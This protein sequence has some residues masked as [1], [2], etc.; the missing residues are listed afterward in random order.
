M[1]REGEGMSKPLAAG[2][3]TAATAAGVAGMTLVGSSVAVSRTLG[4]APL[5]TAQAIRYTLAGVLLLALALG[6][7]VPL[8]RPRGREWLWLSGIAA[9][10]LVAFNVAIVRGTAHAQPTVV[11]VAVACV[12]V[13][14]GVLG[15]LLQGQ[16]PR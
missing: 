10:G 4:Q 7:R 6:L 13:L 16:R 2:R 15:P 12:P 11:A 9:A 1:V 3:R 5:C 14:L 8:P